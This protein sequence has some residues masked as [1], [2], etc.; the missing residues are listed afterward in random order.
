ML[1][2][3]KA[4]INS[5]AQLFQKFFMTEPVDSDNEHQKVLINT[6]AW[7]SIEQSGSLLYD[8][9]TKTISGVSGQNLEWE[10]VKKEVCDGHV[11]EFLTTSSL[12]MFPVI[13]LGGGDT[14]W[15]TC[16]IGKENTT[17]AHC[18]HCRQSKV[19]FHLGH[20]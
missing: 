19:D 13:V 16:T 7:K 3:R 10:V 15:M 5:Y 2:T 20:G 14:E 4:F 18:N 6:F 12:E 17:G 11:A 9:N 8:T 1:V